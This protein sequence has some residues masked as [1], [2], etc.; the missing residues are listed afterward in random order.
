MT[1]TLHLA[2]ALLLLFSGKA[3]IAQENLDAALLQELYDS[4]SL[5][6]SSQVLQNATLK[7]RV[8]D[9]IRDEEIIRK[10]NRYFSFEVKTGRITDQKSS[11]RCWLYATLNTIRPYVIARLQ[12]DDFEFSQTYLY[13]WDKMEKANSFLEKAIARSHLDI[14]DERFQF[15]LSSPVDDNGYWQNAVDLVKKYGCMPQQAMPEVVSSENSQEMIRILNYEL[16]YFAYELRE[17]RNQGSSL[18]DLRQR[19]KEQLKVIYRILAF[20]LGTPVQSFEFR[21]F[22][23]DENGRKVL[24]PY[25]TYTPKS[26]AEEFVVNLEDYAMFANWPARDYYCLYQWESSNNLVDGTPLTFLNLPMDKIKPMMK[27]SILGGE[28]VEFS[29]DVGK[30]CDRK[31]GIMAQGLYPYEDLYGVPF[32]CDKRINTVIGNIASTHAMVILGLDMCEDRVIK[33]KV[34]NS[35]GTDDGDG[36]FFYMYDDW[37]DLYVVR[38]VIKKDYIPPELLTLFEQTPVIIPE[39]EPEQ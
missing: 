23:T 25:K 8:H 22:V 24:T 13:F 3:G 38:V 19:K 14:R 32:N 26:F 6:P 28:P 4:F 20:H 11:G 36:G 31:N 1:K 30:Q 7:Y 9:L 33:W 39:N 21:H 35:W 16:R 34:E 29:A 2:V 18:E 10:H 12:M 5:D 15:I 37:V 17:M 27:E